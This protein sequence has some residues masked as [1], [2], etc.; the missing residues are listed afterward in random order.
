MFTVLHGNME[1]TTCTTQRGFIGVSRLQIRDQPRG[2]GWKNILE[3]C[4]ELEPEL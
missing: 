2:Q 4:K 3:V 1:Y